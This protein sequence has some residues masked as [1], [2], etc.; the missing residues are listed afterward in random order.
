MSEMDPAARRLDTAMKRLEDALDAHFM[1]A[2]DPSV[3]RAEV[4]A[5]LADRLRLAEALDASLARERD[6]QLLADEASEALG[7]AIEEVRAALGTEG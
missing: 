3:L 2:S 6:L 7:A 1:R 5:L 4:A